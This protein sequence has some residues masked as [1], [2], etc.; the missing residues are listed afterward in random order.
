[1]Q[2]EVCA[3]DLLAFIEDSYFSYML[4][5]FEVLDLPDHL[6]MHTVLFSNEHYSA[7]PRMVSLKVP[8]NPS[9]LCVRQLCAV[10]QLA[11]TSR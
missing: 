1:M 5:P 3:L 8:A 4:P 11:T 9:R 10:M 6:V 2:R 7:P